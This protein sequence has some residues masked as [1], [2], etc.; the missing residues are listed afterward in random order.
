[1]VSSNSPSHPSLPGHLAGAPW[2]MAEVAAF[3][4]LSVRTIY[5]LADA[6]QV[7]TVTFGRRRLV[8]DVEVR[9]LATEG[10]K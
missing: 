4:G 8:P 7:R 3:L 5:R 9:R 6:G 1:M 2:R 10:A